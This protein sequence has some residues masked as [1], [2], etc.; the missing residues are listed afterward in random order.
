MPKVHLVRL[1]PDDGSDAG[2]TAAVINRFPC[3]VGRHSGCDFLLDHPMVSRRHCRLTL[4]DDRV[5]VEDL[6]SLNGTWLNG[7]VLTRAAPLADG[8]CLEL[9]EIALL[10]CPGEHPGCVSADHDTSDHTF[11]ERPESLV[12]H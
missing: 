11:V 5:W 6:G 2:N 1:L 9:A 4:W 12:Q 3:I 8:D 7:Q 10:C